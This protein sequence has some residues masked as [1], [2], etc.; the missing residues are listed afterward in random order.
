MDV[1]DDD[2]GGRVDPF[3]GI[4]D[5]GDGSGS[6][7]D[8]GSGDR[9]FVDAFD[10]A[11]HGEAEIEAAFGEEAGGVCVTIYRREVAK[12]VAAGEASGV[13]PVEELKFDGVAIGVVADATFCRMA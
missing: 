12:A 4:V 2:A 5:A 7:D 9:N 3:A 11:L 6:A 13:A 1:G 10:D 8:R